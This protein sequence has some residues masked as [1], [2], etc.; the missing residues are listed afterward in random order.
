VNLVQLT[1]A[2][3]AC[4]CRLHAVAVRLAL[5]FSDEKRIGGVYARCAIQIDT[6]TFTLRCCPFTSCEMTVT[7]GGAGCAVRRNVAVSSHQNWKECSKT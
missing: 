1:G 3:P 7:V 6:F 5:L 2:A 4:V